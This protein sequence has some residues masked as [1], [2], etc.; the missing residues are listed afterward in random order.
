MSFESGMM[1]A[2]VLLFAIGTPLAL[3]LVPPNSVYGVRT[4]KTRA[5]LEVWYASNRSA[6]INMAIAGVAIAAAALVIPRLL[7][8]YAEGVRVLILAA[9]VILAIVIMLARILWQVLRL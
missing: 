9:I 4:A 2:G 5:S 3:Q 1:L 6:G 7:P 8:D